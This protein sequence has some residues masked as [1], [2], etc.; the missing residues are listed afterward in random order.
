MSAAAYARSPGMPRALL[1]A[2]AMLL[3]AGLTVLATPRQRIASTHHVDLETMVPRSFSGWHLDRSIAPLLPSPDQQ[4]LLDRTYDQVLAR[5]YVNGAG[6]RVML[7][8][9]YGGNQSDGMQTHRPEICYPAQGF[10]VTRQRV[11]Q[12]ALDYGVLPVRRLFAV[13]GA[14]TEPIT[15]WLVVGDQQTSFGLA[16]KLATLKYGLTGRIPDGMLVRVSSID[17]DEAHADA[18]QDGF[19]RDMLA[20]MKDKDRVRLLGTFGA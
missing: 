3:A 1:I 12:L 10:S 20:A 2:L 13:Q 4:A 8:I 15:Y 7:S 18:V 14:R 17:A 9:A 19:V 5:T 16:Y 11:A 6:E